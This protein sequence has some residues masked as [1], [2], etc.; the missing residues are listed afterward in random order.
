M[1]IGI[2]AVYYASGGSL[3]NL[4]QLLREWHA[5]GALETHRVVLFASPSAVDALRA[6]LADVIA[7]VDV[8]V[9]GSR[10]RGLLARLWAEQILLPLRARKVDVL[11]C[12]ANVIPYL[13]AAPTVV[14]F[15]NAAPFCDSVTRR[16]LRHAGWWFRFR[17]L[18]WF[19]R[20]SA[21]RATRVIFIS[22]WFRDRLGIDG[23]VIYRGRPEGAGRASEPA[24][25]LLLYVSHLNPYKNIL[26]VID[27]FSRVDAVEW[28][29]VLAGRTNFPWYRDAIVERIA[30]HGLES[31]VMLTGE[32]DGRAVEALLARAS[33]F[34]FASTCE[35]CPTALI[36]A[37]AYGLPVACSNAGVMPEVAGDAVE[38]FDPNDVESIRAALQRVLGDDAF[39][40]QLAQKARARA[41]T[42]ATES[43]V[44]RR[45]LDVLERAARTRP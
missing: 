43:D 36:E 13:R 20:M 22:E 14:T 5:S 31:R 42:F 23:D 27:A 7:H 34:V 18:G 4:A 45:T 19:I 39:R 30:K 16:S 17:L 29:L 44:A 28:K 26:E 9:L 37:L 32:I 25:K 10:G 33:A 21:R 15:Q 12:P 24:E 6:R 1:K 35:N 11:F 41:E 2:S 38:Y 3:T 40:A 8:E